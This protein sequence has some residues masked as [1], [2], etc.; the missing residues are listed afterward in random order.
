MPKQKMKI[1]GLV[2]EYKLAPSDM[3]DPLTTASDLFVL[4]HMGV[5]EVAMKSWSLTIDGF[6]ERPIHINFDD[7][8]RFSKRTIETVHHCAGSP[9]NP[10]VPTRQ[11]ANVKWTGVDLRELLAEAGVKSEATHI[12]A[13]GLDHGE[14]AGE[15]QNCYLKDLPLSR[16]SDGDVLIAYELNDE[17]L[18]A[19]HGFP[20]R[21]VVPGFYGTNSVK[22]LSRLHL[23]P[24]RA[25][26]LF[27]TKLY[28]DPIPAS[29]STK[30]VWE[31]APE[32]IIV[33]PAPNSELRIGKIEVWGW[34]WSESEI[35]SVKIST[36]NGNSWHES[37]LAPR[38]SWSWQRFSFDFHARE[39]GEVELLCCATD[40]NG[41]TQP[42]DGARNAVYST[43]V[44]VASKSA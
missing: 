40:V 10:T 19:E 26:S 31:L 3:T 11:V 35:E 13:Y 44:T 21:L 43:T 25:N 30:P 34:A 41:Q 16:I 20:A 28:N 24:E 22:W 32:S 1:E 4:A 36:D 33:S 8:E 9:L 6:V 17:P 12:W 39:L 38:H 27:T 7:L 37:F 14:F 2:A 23:A 42:L 29:K 15:K 18:S 5:P